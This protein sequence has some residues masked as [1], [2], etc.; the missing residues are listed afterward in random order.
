MD[1]TDY[2]DRTPLGNPNIAVG[3]ENRRQAARARPE[4]T[5]ELPA[6]KALTTRGRVCLADPSST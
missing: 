6:A 2:T 4:R 5:L 1:P 3:P